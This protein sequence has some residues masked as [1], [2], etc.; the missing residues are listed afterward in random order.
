MGFAWEGDISMEPPKLVTL[1]PEKEEE[2]VEEEP[3]WDPPFR[4]VVINLVVVLGLKVATGIAMKKLANSVKAYSK[5]S[6]A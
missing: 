6:E 2:V 5:G 3:F 1:L 4:R